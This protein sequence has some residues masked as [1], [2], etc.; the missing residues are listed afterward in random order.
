MLTS[1]R[2]VFYVEGDEVIGT[3]FLPADLAKDE[4]RAGIV[5]AGGYGG[6]RSEYVGRAED[7]TKER[8]VVLTF[9]YR[10]GVGESKYHG[11][12]SSPGRLTMAPE[13][14]VN[15][16]RGAVRYM[17]NRPKVN[18]DKI[19]LFGA[20]AGGGFVLPAA[21]AEPKVACV[22]CEG[23]IGDGYRMI[24]SSRNPWEFRQFIN[25]IEE[26]RVKRLLTGQS[27]LVPV[28]TYPGGGPGL[29]VLGPEER[30][31]WTETVKWF[32]KLCMLDFQTTLEAC[33]SWLEFKPELDAAKISPRPIMFLGMETSV[34]VPPEE[35]LHAY[36]KAAEP[37]K[38]VMFP[39]RVASSRYAKF[40][41]CQY[42]KY[43]PEI[44]KPIMEWFQNHMPAC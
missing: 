17:L 12:P 2:V 44:L 20:S 38:L 41:S 35:T 36:Q 19:G 14:C 29:F 6:D 32:P 43:V 42:R 31:A 27:D 11:V 24:R 30:K 39:A 37:K 3:L 28:A 5:I 25:K 9:D 13:P 40:T 10:C 7:F 26:D 8:Y 21:S 22:I 23:G 33:D 1:E 16:V 34:I 15:D 18:P 4:Q